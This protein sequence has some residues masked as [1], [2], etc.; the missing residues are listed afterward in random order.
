MHDYVGIQKMSILGVLT[1]FVVHSFGLI[2]WSWHVAT[3]GVCKG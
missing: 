1:I 2:T 3:V